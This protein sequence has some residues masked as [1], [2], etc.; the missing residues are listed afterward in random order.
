MGVGREKRHR[1]GLRLVGA[2]SLLLTATTAHAGSFQVSPINIAVPHDRPIGAITVKNEADEPVSMRVLTYRW[3]QENGEEIYTPTSELLASPPI[4]T[5]KPRGTQLVRVGLRKSTEV[6]EVAYRV[7]L[8]EIPKPAGDAPGIH[9]SLRLN[10]PFYKQPKARGLSRVSWSAR[11]SKDGKLK[12]VAM[13]AGSLHDQINRIDAVDAAGKRFS[14]V[15][16]PG[17]VLPGGRK[18]WLLPEQPRLLA[19]QP[20]RLIVVKPGG[21]EQNAAPV[22]DE[23]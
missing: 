20:I 11:R 1:G 4:L 2:L 5:I 23:G 18:H 21:E 8:E 15:D 3:T 7:I 13:N 17:V 10:L 22:L 19:G 12:L 9:V 16:K 14:L 6:G